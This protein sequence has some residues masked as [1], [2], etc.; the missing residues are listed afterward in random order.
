M[1]H[2]PVVGEAFQ[3]AD[4]GYL[5]PFGVRRK[6]GVGC[7]GGPAL[8]LTILKDALVQYDGALDGL[9]N[10]RIRGAPEF[11]AA[12]AARELGG[13][14]VDAASATVAVHVA[15]PDPYIRIVV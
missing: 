2:V 6:G 8:N 7:E 5:Y 1:D 9:M 11:F 10:T 4:G 13:V 15:A 14:S 12:G 3:F